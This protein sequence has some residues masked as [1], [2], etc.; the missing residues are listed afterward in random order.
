MAKVSENQDFR[1]LVNF[2]LPISV[3]ERLRHQSKETEVPMA[4][5]VEDC[6]RKGLKA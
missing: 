6:L 2:N 4:H 1:V 5:I 3:V